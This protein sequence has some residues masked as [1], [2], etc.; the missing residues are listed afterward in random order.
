MGRALFPPALSVAFDSVFDMS[1]SVETI[2]THPVVGAI[3]A[4]EAELGSSRDAAYFGLSDDELEAA[5]EGC[6]RLRALV[7][8]VELALVAE[9]DERDLARRLGAAST[10]AWLAGR[11]RMRP[12]RARSLVQVANRSRADE[13]PVDYAANVRSA[14]AG[15]GLRATAAALAEGT[16]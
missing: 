11:F 4:V 8:D 7:Y 13:G 2:R 6:E 5:V 10:A 9:A 12:G 15:R 16:S 1:S 3:T 14:V